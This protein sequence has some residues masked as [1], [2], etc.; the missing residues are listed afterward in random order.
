LI[1]RLGK[2]SRL[3]QVNTIGQFAVFCFEI[4]LCCQLQ[5]WR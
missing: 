2:I 5:S 4:G 3:Q 1:G